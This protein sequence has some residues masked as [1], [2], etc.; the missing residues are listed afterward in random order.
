MKRSEAPAASGLMAMRGRRSDPTKRRRRVGPSKRQVE[1]FIAEAREM[2][3]TGRWEGAQPAHFLAAW[4]YLH[5]AVYGVAPPELERE[6]WAGAVNSVKKL[7]RDECRGRPEVMVSYVRWFWR[8][9]KE[10]EDW[11]RKNQREGR[12][13]NWRDAFARRRFFSEYVV[14]LQRTR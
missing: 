9:E 12:V 8:R 13:V 1:K 4:A 7:L 6:E 10:R 3:R 5:T 14:Q 2:M 11:R